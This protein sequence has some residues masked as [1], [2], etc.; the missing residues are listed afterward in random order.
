MPYNYHDRTSNLDCLAYVDE[1]EDYSVDYHG[2]YYDSNNG[3][4]LYIT[5]SG[6]SC[7]DGEYEEE[8]F[9][10]LSACIQGIEAYKGDY[11]PS[12]RTIEELVRQIMEDKQKGMEELDD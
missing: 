6:C 12:I 1:S 7:W 10:T 2:V 5:A 3:T 8:E 9:P 11:E 4:F